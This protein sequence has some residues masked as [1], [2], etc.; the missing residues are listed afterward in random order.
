MTLFEFCPKCATPMVM[1][2]DD[3][4]ERPVCPSCGYVQYRNPAPAAGAVVF[5]NGRLLLVKRAH[6]PYIGKWTIPAGFME[7]GESPEE[8]TVRELK[9]ETNLEVE[10][11][12]LFHVYAGSD[13]P[14]TRAVL[15]LYFA[16]SVTSEV[17]AGDDASDARWFALDELPSDDKIAFESHRRAIARLKRDHPGLF[18]P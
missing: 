16:I 6:E 10:I 12:G 13:D 11:Q 5:D 8:T 7:W 9:E 18:T 4:K 2:I 1:R 3:S 15:I 17:I 14:R